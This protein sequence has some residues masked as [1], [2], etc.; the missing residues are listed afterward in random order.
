MLMEMKR[1]R[2]EV[3]K[4]EKNEEQEKENKEDQLNRNVEEKDLKKNYEVE[5]KKDISGVGVASDSS[6]TDS[7]DTFLEEVD[8]IVKSIA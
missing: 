4:M 7:D 6:S 8:N 5:K 3:K 2:R 1:K